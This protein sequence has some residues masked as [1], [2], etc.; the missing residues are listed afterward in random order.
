M[1]SD[2]KRIELHVYGRVQGVF[3]RSGVKGIADTHD[4][5]GW[6]KNESDDSVT[7]VAEGDEESLQKLADWCRKGTDLS[8]VEDIKIEW[9]EAAGDFKE[10][11]LS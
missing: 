5:V 9:K 3:F 11:T 2:K 10:F 7:V 6:V 4:I 8:R 1:S